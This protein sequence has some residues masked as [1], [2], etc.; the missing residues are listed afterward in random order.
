VEQVLPDCRFAVLPDL[1]LHFYFSRRQRSKPAAKSKENFF[2][3]IFK[4]FRFPVS[5]YF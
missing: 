1:P 2:S 5:Y 4:F 3:G